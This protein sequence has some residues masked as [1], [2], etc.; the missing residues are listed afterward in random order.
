M[1]DDAVSRFFGD[2]SDSARAVDHVFSVLAATYAQAWTKALGEAPIND[3]K[4]AWAFH[5]S[6]FTHSKEAKRSIM[7][8]L[9]NLPTKV[10]N[11]IEFKALCRQAPSAQEIALPQPK[12]DPAI[13][14]MVVNG[15]KAKAPAP[16]TDFRE[17]ARAILQDHAEG[18]KRTPTVVQMAKN[19][20][21]PA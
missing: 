15:L 2:V 10:P 8:A 14:A 11:P 18:R 19:A 16:K 13:V 21:E 5:L 3:I 6:G 20:L 12:A 7:W 4:T 17:W 9:Q 1:N